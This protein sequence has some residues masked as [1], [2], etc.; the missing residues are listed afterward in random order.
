MKVTNKELVDMMVDKKGLFKKLLKNP[1]KTLKTSKI[2]LAPA[3]LTKLKTN[4]RSIKRRIR[5]AGISDPTEIFRRIM[6]TKTPPPPPW[7]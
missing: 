2:E 4:L 3:Q 5:A 1:E 7:K 6:Y